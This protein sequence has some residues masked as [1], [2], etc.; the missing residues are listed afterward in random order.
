MNITLLGHMHGYG[1]A[2]KSLVLLANQLLQRGH[3]VTIISFTSNNCVY[4]LDNKIQYIYIPDDGKNKIKVVYNRFFCMK[5]TLKEL[6]SDLVISF[7]FQLA[8]LAL[9][10]SYF[11]KFKIIYSERGDPSDKEYS[12]LNGIIRSL[13]FPMMDGFVFQT[14]GAK[15]YFSKKIQNKSIV[16]HNAIQFTQ[17]I[18]DLDVCKKKY[19]ISAGRL[20]PQK[21]FSLLIDAFSNI[22]DEF[23][24]YILYIYGDGELR[25]DL[26]NQINKLNLSNRIIL[27]GNTKDL[28]Y[29]MIESEI[30]VLSSKYEGMP[31][32]LMEAMALGLPCVSTD[33]KPGGARELIEDGING[34]IVDID[35]VEMLSSKIKYLIENKDV[36]TLIGKRAK[37]ILDVHSYDIIYDSWNN[38]I[39]QLMKESNK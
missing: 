27:P 24:E 16:I 15:T 32:V 20:H 8:I 6:N 7:W 22:A 25:D 17:D 13:L 26:Q 36:A 34:F 31:N 30:F 2:E 4:N 18:K 5:K 12:G 19:I 28:I 33:C 10:V 23:P 38:Y 35:D 1:G 14:N 37:R 11:L 29:K 21:N 9:F 3:T 39:L